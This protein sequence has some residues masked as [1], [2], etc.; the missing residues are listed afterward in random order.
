MTFLVYVIV[1]YIMILRLRYIVCLGHISMLRKKIFIILIKV[2][3][4]QF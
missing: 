1:R 3:L 4:I 2:I